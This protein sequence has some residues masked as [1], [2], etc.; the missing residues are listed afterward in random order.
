VGGIVGGTALVVLS[1]VL[2][3]RRMKRSADRGTDDKPG[4]SD[5]DK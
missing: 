5:E 4:A 3:R 1:A 2:Y